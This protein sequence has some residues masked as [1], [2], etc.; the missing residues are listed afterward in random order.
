MKRLVPCLM[1]C[2]LLA[3]TSAQ[4]ALDVGAPAP[5]FSTQASL[6][7]KVFTF[8]LND[9]LKVALKDPEFVKK[10]EGLGAIVV[11]DK[12]VTP[13]GHKA[14]VGAEI[15]KLKAVIEAAG[16]FAD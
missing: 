1:F 3:A 9:A 8:K 6:G 2:G 10:Q 12:R 4:A 15:T 5:N 7:G 13:E 11:N 14:F 16:Q